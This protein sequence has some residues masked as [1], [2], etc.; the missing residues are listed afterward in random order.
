M[1]SRSPGL[2]N[3]PPRAAE[4][5]SSVQMPEGTMELWSELQETGRQG[6]TPATDPK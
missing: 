1:G 5:R 2:D 4:A 3:S 6:S